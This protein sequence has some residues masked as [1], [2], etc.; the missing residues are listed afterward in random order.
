MFDESAS[1]YLPPT[2]DLNSNPSS[3][4]EVSDAEMPPHERET[5]SLEES[6]VSFRISG[7]T[8]PLSR[9]DQSDEEPAS[10]GD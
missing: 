8:E 1:W 2:L 6:P 5:E 10:T 9:F 7:P 3:E 4:D